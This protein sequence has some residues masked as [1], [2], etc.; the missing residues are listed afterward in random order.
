MTPSPAAAALTVVHT[1]ALAA[2]WE[3]PVMYSVLQPLNPYQPIHRIKAPNA[4]GSGNGTGG[5]VVRATGLE[6]CW[7]P[8]DSREETYQ[9]TKCDSNEVGFRCRVNFHLDRR[10]AARLPDIRKLSDTR[11]HRTWLMRAWL[12]SLVV[13]TRSEAGSKNGPVRITITSAAIPPVEWI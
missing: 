2:T 11:L 13:L 4:C 10:D 9:R 5:G 3:L 8:D 12:E 7:R 6:V 1:M